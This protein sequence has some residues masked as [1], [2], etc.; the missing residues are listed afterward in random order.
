VLLDERDRP[1]AVAYYQ[2]EAPPQLVTWRGASAVVAG[3][4]RPVVYSALGTHASYPSSGAE[5]VTIG[6]L[7]R[8]NSSTRP[9]ATFVETRAQGSEWRTWLDLRDVRQPWFGYGGGW[10][11]RGRFPFTTGPLGPSPWKAPAPCTRR[12]G[13]PCTELP[14]AGAQVAIRIA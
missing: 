4:R 6:Y 8:P 2:H 9:Q 3:R 13:Q 1:L 5:T 11:N 7:S 12:I 10:G 14:K